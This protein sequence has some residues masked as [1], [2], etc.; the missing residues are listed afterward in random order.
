MLTVVP[1]RHSGPKNGSPMMWSQWTWVRSSEKGPVWF[2]ARRTLPS[3]RM[4]V[5]PSRI[6][7]VPSASRASTHTV[8]PP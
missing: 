8:L 6:T 3:S 4:P 2:S 5:P 1:L 7:T